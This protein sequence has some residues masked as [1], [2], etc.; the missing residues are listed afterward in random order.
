[1]IYLKEYYN[2]IVLTGLTVV[3]IYFTILWS[4]TGLFKPHGSDSLVIIIKK[5]IKKCRRYE[6]IFLFIIT[7]PFLL[8]CT[9]QPV[10]QKQDFTQNWR[11]LLGNDSLAYQPEYND[12]TCRILDLPHDWSIEGKFS[13]KNPTGQAGGGLPTG[14]GW[15]RKTFTLSNRLKNKLVFIDFDGVYR[16][17]EV[18]I[19]GHYLGKRPNGYISFRYELTDF[20]NFGENENVIAVKV[21]NSL[22]PNSRWYT[23]S[24]IYRNVWL[25]I[26]EKIYI[27][28][29]GL[30]V[31]TPEITNE[32]ATINF[33]IKLRKKIKTPTTGSVKTI[34]Y[35]MDDKKVSENKTSEFIIN[36]TILN[37][38]QKVKVVNPILWNTDCPYIYKAITT[39][40]SNNKISDKYETQ[41]GIRFFEFNEKNG[42]FL[43]GKPLK[44][45]GVNNHHD[46]GS[47]G[48][49]VNIR[50]IER[51]LEIL[52]DMGC[53]AIRTA[54]N[55]PA[56]ELL[57]L[58]DKMGFIVMDEAFDVWRKNKVKHDYHEEWEA[59]HKKDLEDFIKRDRNH[60]SVF[61]WSIGNEIRE[62]FDS[63]GISITRELVDI[64]KNLDITRPVT[65]ALT[66]NIPE[67][68]F[69]YQ[70][71]ALDLLSFNYKQEAY[72]EFP[73]N[74]P[75]GK[76]IASENI[77]ALA[78]RGHYDMPSDSIMNWPPSHNVPFNGNSDFT[79]SAYDHVSAYW[80]STHE[81]TWK[82]VK[83][84][85]FI[86]GFFIWSGFD[87]LGEP[88][89]Y[90][91][92]ARSSYFGIIDLAGFPKDAYYLYQ[93]EWT[94]KT[95]LHIFPHWNLP[96]RQAGWQP[97]E[98]IDV[99]A[100]YN[101][102]DEVELFLNDTSL[103]VRKKEEDT[104]HVMWRVKYKPGILKAISRKKGKDVLERIVKTADK[105]YMIELKADRLKIK[106]NGKDLSFITIRI[107]DKDNVLVPDADNLVNFKIFGKG[108][109]AGV[110]NGYQA[111]ME[112]FRVSYRKAFNGLCLVIIQSNGEKGIIT[113]D[114]NSKGL[115]PATITIESQ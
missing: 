53:N 102:A 44:I 78:T 77:S 87:Y 22:Q 103:G 106:A 36:D 74:Y 105:P 61:I 37:T 18:W 2:S 25:I 54:H 90:P 58:C 9:K 48:A 66:E 91:W 68:N 29:M 24:G 107:L 5:Q 75:G 1:M 16:N 64:V 89:P 30:F 13:K 56:P 79:V 55:P 60:P 80:G 63:S 15:Y 113:L 38:N 112:S 86:S 108:F 94:T 70:S 59:W 100:Y 84:Y 52:K 76:M 95:I 43:N 46:L 93:S 11:F 109:I 7:I 111:S 32:S 50:A 27:D 23:G 85:D 69:I 10:R 73:Q 19:N 104:M 21:D 88:T 47:L 72:P 82:I 51:Q 65:C 17:S 35:D 101:N 42:F 31:T 96:D 14:I 71:G 20:L 12:S 3:F 40:Y 49:A 33:D 67:K 39:V 97:G 57:D 110:D 114:A 4:L 92:P 99:W 115:I 98:M 28:H 45:L 34:I 62:Q 83:K 81:E 6:T 41:F 26:T 8:S